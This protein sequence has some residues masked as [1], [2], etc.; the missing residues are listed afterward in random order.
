MKRILFI[1]LLSNSAIAQTL[2]EVTLPHFR[3]TTETVFGIEIYDPF[4]GIEETDNPARDAWIAEKNQQA[5]RLLTQVAGY[6]TIGEEIEQ[7]SGGSPVRGYVP[8]VNNGYTYALQVDSRQGI[9]Q[10]V[11][12]ESP[13]DSGKIL[14]TTDDIKTQSGSQYSIS[15]FNPSPDNRYLALEIN[16]ERD[17]MEIRVFD[18]ATARMTDDVVDASISYYP[19]WLPDS[20]RLFYTQLSLPSDSVD[21]F[22]NVTVKLHALGTDQQQDPLILSKSSS[23]NLPYGPGDFPTV[24]VLPDSTTA[25]CSLSR[26][27]AQY[28]EYFL[29]PLE[30]LAQPSS[31]GDGWQRLNT[32]EDKVVKAVFD[33][34]SAYLLSADNDSTTTV[35]RVNLRDLTNTKVIASKTDGFI[36]DL[37]VREHAIYLESVTDGISSIV[38]IDEHGKAEL[39]LPFSGDVVLKADGFPS[40]A[41]GQG[42]FFGLANWNKGYGVYYYDHQ[43]DTVVRT[44]IRPL[45]TYDLP[46]D[47]VVEEVQVISHDSVQVP[48]SIIYC[49]GLKRDGNNPVILEAYGA[50]GISLEPYLEVEMLAWYQRGGILAKAH[51]RGGSEKGAYWHTQGRKDKKA[52]SWKDLIACAQHLVDNGYTRPAKL[53]VAGASAGGI[54]VGRAITERP[55]LFGAAVLEYPSVNPVRLASTID[56]TIHYEEFGDPTDSVEFQYLYQM[57]PYVNIHP[58]KNYP[59][60]LLTAGTNDTRVELWQPVKFAA[61][62]ESMRGNDKVT[63]L[64]VHDNGHGASDT[65]EINHQIRDRLAFFLWQLGSEAEPAQE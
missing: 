16:N 65:A 51:V 24:Q 53:G 10:I 7:F 9:Q 5:D 2:D 61:K 34:T 6:R 28:T 21:L 15:S 39:P 33:D 49:K 64:K 12:Y 38:R 14:I 60:V 42:L 4:R 57:D 35:T 56:G 30:E 29:I 46:D 58:G 63:L 44:H 50:Y 22:D 11:R 3:D 20:R 41:S 17:E 37:E 45:G 27:I 47:L 19:Y 13:L 52:N 31:E 1:L 26:G 62:M 25:R 43:V 54:A 55:D 32:A 40:K 59:A 8:V 36:S 18:I 48:M 23:A